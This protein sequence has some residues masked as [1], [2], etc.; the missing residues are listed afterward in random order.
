MKK[1]DKVIVTH[2]DEYMTRLHQS[3]LGK[4]QI[5]RTGII[6]K[7]LYNKNMAKYEQ[8]NEVYVRMDDDGSLCIF[9][10]EE[11]SLEGGED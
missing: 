9:I 11:L 3:G 1:G 4:S 7:K 5:G 10:E 6:E 2:E 8:G